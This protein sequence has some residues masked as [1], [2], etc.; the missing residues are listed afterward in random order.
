VKESTKVIH[1]I[2]NQ[3]PHFCIA[4]KIWSLQHIG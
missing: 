4:I 2:C 1:K 3:T